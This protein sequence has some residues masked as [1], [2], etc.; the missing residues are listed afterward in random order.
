MIRFS[1]SRQCY[2]R[3]FL[4]LITWLSSL[5]IADASTYFLSPSGS[6]S[7]ACSSVSPCFTISHVDTLTHAGDTVILDNGTYSYGTQTINSSGTSGNPITYQAA[8]PCTGVPFGTPSCSAIIHSSSGCQPGIQIFG[9]YVTFF[10]FQIS[11]SSNFCTFYSAQNVA[12][13]AWPGY[14]GYKT[15]TP[16]SLLTV[17]PSGAGTNF[18]FNTM[19]IDQTNQTNS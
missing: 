2:C 8:T 1:P 5:A 12:V 16:D 17:D 6:D 7:N 13:R 10:G 3:L 11:N 19:Y 14:G 15:S 4:V 9:G 18:T